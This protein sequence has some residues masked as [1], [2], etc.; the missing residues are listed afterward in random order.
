MVNFE[1]L[2]DNFPEGE[3]MQEYYTI[4]ITRQIG[5][6]GSFVGQ[7]VARRLG[8]SYI[9]RE[10]L[11]QAATTLEEDENL[12]CEREECISSFWGKLV[13]ALCICSPE[14]GYVPPSFHPINDNVLFS[15]EAKIIHELSERSN[16]VIVGRGAFHVL[17]N[18]P[19]MFSVFLHASPAFR[20]NR[21]MDIYNIADRS[22]AE[23]VIRN[24]DAKRRKFYETIA[25]QIWT[26]STGYHLSID[27]GFAGFE[28]A[29]DTIHCMAK[30]FI[31]RRRI[32]Q[33]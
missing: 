27:T 13:N 20:I 28:T 31:E 2:A 8:F 10:I 12:L 14:A 32:D 30:N 25:D 3:S 11:R 5:S 18:N 33:R 4:A 16:A 6:G 7:E 23:A 29:I 24:S 9:D 22:Q 26:D 1:H 17:R 21:I 19:R 15:T